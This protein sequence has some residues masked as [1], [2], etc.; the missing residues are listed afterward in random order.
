MYVGQPFKFDT[1]KQGLD[2]N[3]E[4]C[5]LFQLRMFESQFIFLRGVVHLISPL[6][7]LLVFLQPHTVRRPV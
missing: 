5:C 2:V 1:E 3:T 6:D 7:I 4:R